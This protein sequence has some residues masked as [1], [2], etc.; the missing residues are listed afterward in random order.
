MAIACSANCL[1]ASSEE[2]LLLSFG[3]E[4]FVSIAT[5]QKQLIAKAPAVASVI[6]AE[7]AT[8]FT[9]IRSWLLTDGTRQDIYIVKESM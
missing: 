9:R 5:G 6:T 1:A 4:E 7:G 8:A 2:D 3:E